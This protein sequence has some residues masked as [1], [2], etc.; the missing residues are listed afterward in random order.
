MS[1]SLIEFTIV[2][3]LTAISFGPNALLSVDSAIRNGWP[4]ALAVPIGISVASVIYSALSVSLLGA[5]LAIYP[6]IIPT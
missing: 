2:W 1:S 6:N 4:K 3:T 5:I